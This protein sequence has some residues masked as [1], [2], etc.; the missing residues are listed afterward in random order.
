[1]GELSDSENSTAGLEVFPPS[2]YTLDFL[3]IFLTVFIIASHNICKI[4]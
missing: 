2:L 4:F 3:S 1:M